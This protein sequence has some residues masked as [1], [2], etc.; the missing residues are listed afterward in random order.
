MKEPERYWRI[1][2]EQTLSAPSVSLDFTIIMSS[3]KDEV[4]EEFDGQLTMK[5]MKNTG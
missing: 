4:I 3:L 2:P 5:G 1:F